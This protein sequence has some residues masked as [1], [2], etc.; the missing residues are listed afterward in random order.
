MSAE[1]WARLAE[2]SRLQIIEAARA[3]A[4]GVPPDLGPDDPQHP[5]ESPE[6]FFRRVAE[7]KP[8]RKPRRR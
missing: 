7:G 4:E 2:Q 5:L 8:Q 6:D 3:Q 1:G